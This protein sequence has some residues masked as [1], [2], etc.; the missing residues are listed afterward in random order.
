MPNIYSHS[1]YIIIILENQKLVKYILQICIATRE[2][3]RTSKNDKEY[4][5]KLRL[6]ILTLL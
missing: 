1:H 5:S 4:K 6:R 3:I 2:Q